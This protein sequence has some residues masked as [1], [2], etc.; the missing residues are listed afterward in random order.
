M[1]I[2]SKFSLGFRFTLSQLD[3]LFFNQVSRYFYLIS[4]LIMGKVTHLIFTI[5]VH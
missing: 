5:E 4:L 1:K 3:K 2:E